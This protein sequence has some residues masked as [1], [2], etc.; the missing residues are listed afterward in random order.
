MI[1]SCE[2]GNNSW[3]DSNIMLI[4]MSLLC[5]NWVLL[6]LESFL[7]SPAPQLPLHSCLQVV[8]GLL[9]E[10]P[11][12]VEGEGRL[13]VLVDAWRSESHMKSSIPQAVLIREAACVFFP[14]RWTE[15]GV[16]QGFEGNQ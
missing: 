9:Q 6:P 3:I 4:E 2:P 8:D 7:L 12:V 16:G 11:G 15:S 10:L 14:L 1:S 5:K 13:L